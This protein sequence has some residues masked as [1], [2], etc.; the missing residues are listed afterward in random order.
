MTDFVAF[1]AACVH[2]ADARRGLTRTVLLEPF[3]MAAVP[4]SSAQY[5]A[6]R[7][8]A[9]EIQPMEKSRVSP[10][11]VARPTTNL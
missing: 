3:S 8:E 7:L 4:V 11:R 6:G 2:L 9:S 1:G 10:E 5:V